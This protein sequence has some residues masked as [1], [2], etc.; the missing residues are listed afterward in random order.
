MI[1]NL[2]LDLEVRRLNAIDE[3]LLHR[4]DV[5]GLIAGH[6][7]ETVRAAFVREA[8]RI[9]AVSIVRAPRWREPRS[10]P[11]LKAV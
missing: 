2:D 7:R 5:A 10:R 4:I 11:A 9:G 6:G 1:V 8:E 3:P